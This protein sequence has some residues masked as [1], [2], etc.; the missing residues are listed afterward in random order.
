MDFM[1][2]SIPACLLLHRPTLP[3]LLQHVWPEA[4]VHVER[5]VV[6]PSHQY[7][8]GYQV[9]PAA[10]AA[11]IAATI[12]TTAAATAIA[13]ATAASSGVRLRSRLAVLLC[14][15]LLLLLVRLLLLLLLLLWKVGVVC[16]WWLLG[17]CLLV[18]QLLLQDWQGD[19]F[20]A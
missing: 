2:V 3:Q 13:T 1:A 12:A 16:L 5:Q 6:P 20:L 15:L 18:M 14:L 4:L 10:T 9:T 11:T 7:H 19:R 8:Q 17:D